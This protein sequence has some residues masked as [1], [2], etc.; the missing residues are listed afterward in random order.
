VAIP[1]SG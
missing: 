1:T